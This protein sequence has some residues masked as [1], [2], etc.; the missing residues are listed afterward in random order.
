M[1]WE[2]ERD[3]INVARS[4]FFKGTVRVISSDTSRKN[5]N[6]RYTTAPLI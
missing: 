2:T 5:N 4:K 6:T 3:K 1:R